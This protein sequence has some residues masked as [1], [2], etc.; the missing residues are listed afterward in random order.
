MIR[1]TFNYLTIKTRCVFVEH[2]DLFKFA[3][4]VFVDRCSLFTV[5]SNTDWTVFVIRPIQIIKQAK[6]E[7]KKSE[8]FFLP[9]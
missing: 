2:F 9:N 7:Q 3:I 8:T 6:H 5:A 4:L 1:D